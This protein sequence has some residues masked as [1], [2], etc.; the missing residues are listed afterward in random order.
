MI[1]PERINTFE[2][3]DQF[4]SDKLQ[5]KLDN[6]EEDFDVSNVI[7]AILEER[8]DSLVTV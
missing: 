3:F 4:E 1:H 8:G 6:Y 7:E 5:S 2:Y